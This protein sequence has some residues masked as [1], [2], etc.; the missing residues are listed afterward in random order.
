MFPLK[1]DFTVY[2]GEIFNIYM[3][4]WPESIKLQICEII[5]GASGPFR[6]SAKEFILSEI[7]IPIPDTESSSVNVGLENYEF[8]SKE[9]FYM[10]GKDNKLEAMTQSGILRTGAFW[11]MDEQGRILAPPKTKSGQNISKAMKNK[12][13]IAALGV[14]R[15]QDISELAKWVIQSN[16]DPNDPHNADLINLIRVK[17][18]HKIILFKFNISLSKRLYRTLMV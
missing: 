2:W 5:E 15:M 11:G 4:Y 10:R 18:Y 13:A 6:L 1:N 7:I 3:I 16:L 8:A 12:D 9:D 17:K 14:S